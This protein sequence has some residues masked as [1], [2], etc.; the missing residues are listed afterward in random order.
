MWFA[1]ACRLRLT[2]PVESS[3]RARSARVRRTALPSRQRSAAHGHSRD[4]IAQPQTGSEHR[5]QHGRRQGVCRPSGHP[6]E[7]S[8]QAPTPAPPARRLTAAAFGHLVWPGFR[9]HGLAPRGDAHSANCPDWGAR[10]SA[11]GVGVSPSRPETPL[12]CCVT[13]R[14]ETPLWRQRATLRPTHTIQ[15]GAKLGRQARECGDVVPQAAR[16]SAACTFPRLPL[17]PVPPHARQGVSG[18]KGGRR[19]RAAALSA[20]DGAGVHRR[21]RRRHRCQHHRAGGGSGPAN[22]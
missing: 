3:V 15:R 5:A 8:A 21:D 18:A 16:H 20:G 14:D 12:R 9:H 19:R 4:G 22:W 17:T 6:H 1:L 2:E 7:A 11:F 10:R 13:A